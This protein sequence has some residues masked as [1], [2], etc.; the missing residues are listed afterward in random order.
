MFML[1]IIFCKDIAKHHQA[2][3]LGG[4][5]EGIAEENEINLC[6]E[7]KDLH[8]SGNVSSFYGGSK[9][10]RD[11]H[12]R[13]SETCVGLLDRLKNAIEN[14]GRVF[15]ENLEEVTNERINESNEMMDKVMSQM[16]DLCGLTEDDCL[17]A[18]SVIVR[19]APLFHIFDQ[20][21]EDGKVC[22][23]QMVADGSIL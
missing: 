20:L 17:K 5:D 22:M 15:F 3:G 4:E 23:A 16:N 13:L 12:N 18:M 10:K 6:L 7:A 9:R 21:D 1:Y 19:S 8:V 11:E 2:D 14:F